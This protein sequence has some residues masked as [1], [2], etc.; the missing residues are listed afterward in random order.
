MSDITHQLALCAISQTGLAFHPHAYDQERYEA[1]LRLAGQM[2][3]TLNAPAALDPQL[4]ADFEGYWRSEIRAGVP[5]YITPK[6]GVGAVVFNEDDELLLICRS[7]SGH[8][9]YPTGWLDVGLTPAETAVKEVREETGL[10][11]EAEKL[12][13]VFDSSLRRYPLPFHMIS[14]KC[15]QSTH[16]RAVQGDREPAVRAG[17]ATL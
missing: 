8:W 17:S 4:A 14:T 3:A 2:T 11:V 6:V 13:G 15:P 5:G 16:R 9:L 12:L 10:A 1:L 7:D